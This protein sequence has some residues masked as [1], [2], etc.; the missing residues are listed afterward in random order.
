MVTVMFMSYVPQITYCI[1]LANDP[2]Y[3][4]TPFEVKIVIL[5]CQ[6][7]FLGTFIVQR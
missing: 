3:K 7:T 6:L 2:R 5:L 1:Y 4:M